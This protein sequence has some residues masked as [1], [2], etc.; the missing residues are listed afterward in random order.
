MDYWALLRGVNVGGNKIVSMAQL[1]AAFAK[2]GFSSVQT[3]INSG[4]VWFQSEEAVSTLEEMV[5][6][7]MRERFASPH[8]WR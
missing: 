6:T 8:R 5:Q 7:L 1:R 4:N 3:Y 2:A